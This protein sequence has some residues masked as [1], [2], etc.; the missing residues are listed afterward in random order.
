[1]PT[2][3]RRPSSTAVLLSLALL[4]AA[5]TVLDDH[6][7]SAKLTALAG[8]LVALALPTTAGLLAALVAAHFTVLIEPQAI[9]PLS[10]VDLM[11]GATLFRSLFTTTLP[12]PHRLPRIPLVG[13]VALAVFLVVGGVATLLSGDSTSLTSFGRITLYLAVAA[14]PVA[15]LDARSRHL[16]FAGVAGIALGDAV[17][18]LAQQSPTITT[19]FPIGRYL[20][21]LG[22][23]AQFG[24]PIAVAILMVVGCPTILP[25]RFV[26]AAVVVVLLAGLAGSATRSAAGALAVG[27]LVILAD[28]LRVRGISSR[29]RFGTGFLAGVGLVLALA[30]ASI[31]ASAVG[32]DRGSA[33]VR[34]ESLATGWDYLTAFPFG[35]TGLGAIPGEFPAYNTWLALAIGLS[36]PASVA[37]AVFVGSAVVGLGRR[38][39][40]GLTAA[41][42]AVIACSF[43]E[44]VVFAGSSLTITWTVLLGLGLAAHRFPEPPGAESESGARSDAE[45]D[46]AGTGPRPASARTTSAPSLLETQ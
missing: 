11:L 35:P 36:I 1:M 28:Q 24:V 15:G 29:L 17:G 38:D 41:I 7:P 45:L 8:I 6:A 27:S 34:V 40:L 20:G 13:F 37:F 42:T 23:P 33:S 30:V 14:I 26:R 46:A 5:G 25:N 9:G 19:N 12:F 16:V 21:A 10:T 44:N 31:G 4:V 39:R 43:T 32:L 18:A 3:L 22:D 2:A